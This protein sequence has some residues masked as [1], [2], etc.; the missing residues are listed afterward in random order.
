MLAGGCFGVGAGIGCGTGPVSFAGTANSFGA[1][2][3]GVTGCEL[4]KES[5]PAAIRKESPPAR[6]G[7]FPEDFAVLRFSS[8]PRDIAQHKM[9][10][11]EAIWRSNQ[12]HEI[13]QMLTDL[14]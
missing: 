7:D 3:G 6:L 4:R 11:C 13:V 8:D 9:N 14:K 5:L 1:A 2:L 10:F 12:E